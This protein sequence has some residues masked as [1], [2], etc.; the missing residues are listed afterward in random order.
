MATTSTSETVVWTIRRVRE[1]GLT[2]GGGWS[3]I[4][5]PL[6]SSAPSGHRPGGSSWWLGIQLQPPTGA[7][8][9][10]CLECRAGREPNLGGGRLTHPK[11]AGRCQA[12]ALGDTP[13]GKGVQAGR[14]GFRGAAVDTQIAACSRLF[15][16]HLGGAGQ[17]TGGGQLHPHRGLA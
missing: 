4:T 14:R 16:G 7:L 10:R 9:E 8:A 13:P 12:E 5:S 15:G 17:V 11:G 2:A 6:V 3:A 1:R